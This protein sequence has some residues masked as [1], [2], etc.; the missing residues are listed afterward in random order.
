[1]MTMTAIDWVADLGVVIVNH[2][3]SLVAVLMIWERHRVVSAVTIVSLSV[4]DEGVWNGLGSVAV[5]DLRASN[6]A[7]LVGGEIIY[8]GIRS[9]ADGAAHN[10]FDTLK[11]L[12]KSDGFIVFIPRIT[13]LTAIACIIRGDWSDCTSVGILVWVLSSILVDFSERVVLFAS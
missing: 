6:D 1:M 2:S 9:L 7:T 3:S 5:G 4:G 11:I 13:I 12:E 8:I 10:A